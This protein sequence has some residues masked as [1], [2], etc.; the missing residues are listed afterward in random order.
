MVSN[1]Q[2]ALTSLIGRIKQFSLNLLIKTLLYTG[3]AVLVLIIFISAILPLFIYLLIG[4]YSNGRQL[5]KEYKL[6]V[7]H[8]NEQRTINS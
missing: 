6:S 1:K 3:G 5:D 4:N 7:N 8:S 2:N